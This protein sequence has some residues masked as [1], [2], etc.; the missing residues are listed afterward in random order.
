MIIFFTPVLVE[1][2]KTKPNNK[3]VSNIYFN[4]KNN[5]CN[6]VYN[7]VMCCVY[8]D[9]TDILV[10]VANPLLYEVLIMRS[11]IKYP[12]VYMGYNNMELFIKK[13]LKAK[14]IILYDRG[15]NIFIGIMADKIN[16]A[17]VDSGEIVFRM[18]NKFS[19]SI[20]RS[21]GMPGIFYNEF[22][23]IMRVDSR[24]FNG[25]INMFG[26]KNGTKRKERIRPDRRTEPPDFNNRKGKGKR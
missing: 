11:Q 1:N 5:V 4:R 18:C 25:L 15:I 14:S 17:M 13:T 6:I 23:C 19:V 16:Y 22:A 9:N 10:M 8:F 12:L 7:K 24:L 20:R 21:Y 3:P 2:G 26:G